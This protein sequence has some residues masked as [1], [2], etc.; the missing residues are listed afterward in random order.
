[1]YQPSSAGYAANDGDALGQMISS[2]WWTP[3]HLAD[4][5]S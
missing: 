3:W 5:G 1:M 2:V 4:W